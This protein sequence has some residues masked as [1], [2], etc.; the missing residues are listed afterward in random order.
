MMV[1]PS[2]I[3]VDAD[4]LLALCACGRKYVVVP[5]AAVWAGAVYCGHRCQSTPA[6]ASRRP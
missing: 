6:T 1:D 3:Y 5:K 4:E 2:A